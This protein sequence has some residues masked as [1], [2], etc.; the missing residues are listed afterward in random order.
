MQKGVADIPDY[1][2]SHYLC[3]CVETLATATKERDMWFGFKPFYKE[4][5][6]S[7][8]NELPPMGDR[9]PSLEERVARLE[10]LLMKK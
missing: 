9:K 4:K 6:K 7:E 5:A 1:I 10:Q 2:L 8:L 3:K